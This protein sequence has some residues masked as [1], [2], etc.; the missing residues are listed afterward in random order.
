MQTLYPHIFG[1]W[2]LVPQLTHIFLNDI[3][4][5]LPRHTVLI[6]FLGGLL[7]TALTFANY[8]KAQIVTTNSD[9]A[10]G[11]MVATA[12]SVLKANGVQG[13]KLD[14]AYATPVRLKLIQGLLDL[15][16]RVFEMPT[17]TAEITALSVD[18]LL[19]YRYIREGKKESTRSIVGSI[20]VTLTQRDGSVT[21]THVSRI[22]ERH[23]V[24]AKPGEL[25]DGV[26][27]MV[28]F[29]SIDDGGR[30]SGLKRVM[31]PAL[32]ITAVAVTIFLLFNVRSQ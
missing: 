9:H 4:T 7:L 25:D 23:L 20:G 3:M 14:F 28:S 31:E 30:R 24:M 11:L 6:S 15:G 1:L 10:V 19:T 12:D 5:K 13:F 16:Y 22:N 2:T 29:A 17:E 32:I 26:W 21:A 8:A 27:Q 18:P